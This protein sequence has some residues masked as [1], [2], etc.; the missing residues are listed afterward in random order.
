VNVVGLKILFC[1]RVIIPCTREGGGGSDAGEEAKIIWVWESVAVSVGGDG[2]GDGDGC[3]RGMLG[4]SLVA[5]CDGGRM[6][7]DTEFGMEEGEEGLL[8]V[9]VRAGNL[10]SSKMTCWA[11]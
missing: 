4:A 6:G 1:D 5:G 9:D 8:G 2:G 10:V 11:M 3:M 7:T